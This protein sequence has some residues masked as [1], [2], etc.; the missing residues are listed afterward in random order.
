MYSWKLLNMTLG[1]HKQHWTSGHIAD[2]ICNH[3]SIEKGV[4]LDA[5]YGEATQTRIK[6]TEAPYN[7]TESAIHYVNG[8]EK[9]L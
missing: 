4:G 9:Q 2:T 3:S 8:K 5:F 7:D 1:I 6:S